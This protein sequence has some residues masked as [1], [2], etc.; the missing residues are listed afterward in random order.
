MHRCRLIQARGSKHNARTSSF[1][2]A[3]A[4]IHR[5]GL[6]EFG[7]QSLSITLWSFTT[8]RMSAPR[9]FALAAA[10]MESRGLEK[11]GGQAL[12]TIVWSFSQQGVAAS[13]LFSLVSKEAQNRGFS[14]FSP[15]NLILSIWGFVAA[16]FWGDDSPQRFLARLGQVCKVDD[17][18]TFNAPQLR[19]L[20]YASLAARLEVKGGDS[21]SLPP[22][23]EESVAASLRSVASTTTASLLQ[24]DVLTELRQSLGLAVEDEYVVMGALVVDGAIPGERVCIEV[25]GPTHFLTCVEEEGQLRENG[26]TLLK[27]RL[28]AQAGWRVVA[29]S[30]SEWNV[31]SGSEERK[32]WLRAKL[33]K[34]T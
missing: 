33:A 14:D 29:I 15:Q 27:R 6:E 23:L 21:F 5:R 8:A 10:E 7:E 32:K 11:F 31:L 12:A 2:T 25:D 30:F 17:S 3:A 26:S 28:L 18:V 22:E 19:Q 1:F 4:E 34:G 16:G 20:A 13:P 9:L 24:I